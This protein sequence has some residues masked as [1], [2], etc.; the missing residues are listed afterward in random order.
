MF[1]AETVSALRLYSMEPV[2]FTA[3]HLPNKAISE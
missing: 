3:Q 2:P 1:P